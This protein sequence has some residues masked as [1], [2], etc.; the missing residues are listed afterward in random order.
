MDC[1][2]FLACLLFSS[3]VGKASSCFCEHY[4]WSSWSSCSKTC[5]HG[6]QSRSRNIIYDEHY[7]RNNCEQL[8]VKIESRSCNEQPC[9]INCQLGDF[10]P[11]SECDPCLK[12]Q[13]RVRSL[14]RPSQ[15]GG[16]SCA[17]QL[18]DSR[19]CIPTK[20][21]NIEE[22]DCTK[23][24][25]CDSGR[26]IDPKLKCNG[27]NDCGDNSDERG[28]RRKIEPKRSFENIPGVQLMG[29]GYNYLSGESRG[30]ILDNSFFGG[31]RE[32]VSGNGTG[33]NRKLYRL[34]ANVESITFQTKDEEDD[35]SSDFYNSLINFAH[36][37]SQS[38]I[39]QGSGSR[40]S[41]I[42][43]LF[44]SKSKTKRTSSSS[45]KEA[46]QASYKKN[47]NFIRI[48][49]VISVS[50]FRM[51]PDNLWL[52]DVFLR[53]L[54]HLPLEYNYPLYSRIFDDFGTHY[55]TAGSMGGL[56]DL[57]YQY[58]AEELKSSGL[59][60]SESTEC[61]RTET[62][63]RFLFFK[64]KTVKHICTTNKMSEQHAGSFLQSSEK[65]ISLV[66]GGRAE[67]AA[68]LAW[69]KKGS[70]PE[71][72][73]Y[74]EWSASTADNPVVVDFELKPIVDLLTG[75]PCAVTKRRNLLKAFDEYL[76]NFDPCRCSLCPNN[77]RTVL[78]D[79]ECHCVCQPGTYGESCEKRAPD[80]NSVVVDGSWSCWSAWSSCDA[81]SNKKRT[82]QCNNP[83]PR[84]G[85]KPCEGPQME[86]DYCYVALFEDKGALCINDNEDKKEVD[87]KH[88]DP[89]S[90][91]PKPEPPEHGLLANEKTWYSVAE[92]VEIICFSG[93]ELSGFQFLRCLP[94]GT[95]KQE[96]VECIRSTCPR[97]SATDDVTIYRFKSVYKVGE[98][99]QLSCRSGFTVT[100]G[101]R[102]TCGSDYEWSPPIRGDLTCV[103]V[104]QKASQGNC[105]PGEKQVGSQCVC[106]SSE[107]DCG[108]DTEDI[109]AYD[110]DIDDLVTVSQCNFFAEQCQGLKRLNFLNNGTCKDANVNWARDRK[111]L[112]ARSTK[113]EQCGYDFCYDWERCT[114]SQCSCLLPYQCPKNNEQLFCI[115]TGSSGRQRTVNLCGLGATKCTKLKAE[116]LHDGPCAE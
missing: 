46:L 81:F 78:L 99:I 109:C 53:A 33:P 114:G 22:A 15:F 7:R 38:G 111:S 113:R 40:S 24:F 17:G 37:G 92:E 13:F 94:D 54:N 84:N 63:K 71:H 67:Y 56:Y 20:L 30:E 31:S 104:Q 82:R 41:G 66:K 95:W 44:H 35:V 108:H 3:I 21:C 70:F 36:S 88:P 112:S 101:E 57:L 89:D 9:P 79:T 65:S 74:A 106:M 116:I 23:R 77:A 80:Y 43:I 48:H 51:K 93:Y 52:S 16:Q 86:E 110:E 96:P 4:P 73:V 19:P 83:T 10:G 6:S 91:C 28:C 14:Q 61:S 98:V 107:E 100:G 58:S 68:K 105:G 25:Q 11:W 49:K 64:K 5:T 75:F 26:C 32:T 60:V 90:G 29:N 115:K 2:I 42:P 103:K 50:E 47:S 72:N 12:K 59:T 85:G 87:Q 102:Y 39:Y 62:T 18:S 69:Q 97:P 45:F 76:G 34:P 8:C 1:S 27:D 55:I